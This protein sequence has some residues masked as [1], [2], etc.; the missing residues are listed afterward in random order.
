MNTH[1][2]QQEGG[3]IVRIRMLGCNV[4]TSRVYNFDFL[5]PRENIVRIAVRERAPV[6][7]R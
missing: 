6:N 5:D 1:F 7:L 3:K 4:V 2:K